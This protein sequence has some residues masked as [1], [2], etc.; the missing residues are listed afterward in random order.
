MSCMHVDPTNTLNS[1]VSYLLTQT[2]IHTRTHTYT[3]GLPEE[4]SYYLYLQR[5]NGEN[6][7]LAGKEI[8]Q[9]SCGGNHTAVLTTEN[10]LWMCGANP[11]GE[12][13]LGV[14][15][16]IVAE[17]TKVPTD[18]PV[19]KQIACGWSNH[20]A[21]LTEDG[22]L[23][24][25]GG[26]LSGGLARSGTKSS[27]EV[28]PFEKSIDRLCISSSSD[29]TVVISGN[30]VYAAGKNTNHQLGYPDVKNRERLV[31]LPFHTNA[32]TLHVV[33]GGYLTMVATGDEGELVL[34]EVQVPDVLL[35][36][37]NGEKVDEEQKKL[38]EKRNE[39]MK[40]LRMKRPPADKKTKTN[41]S[42]T[43][44]TT[45]TTTSN[46]KKT[47]TSGKGTSGG[48]VSTKS[49]VTSTIP[50]KNPNIR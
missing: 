46:S 47:T 37:K 18:L 7:S 43:T 36:E 5:M 24:T 3:Q 31:K 19:I 1:Y 2:L 44:A 8:K 17:F 6:S 50:R 21:L 42:N 41:T 4:Q 34:E 20:T 25:C 26:G 11:K 9:I 39:A 14:K 16:K 10:E 12:L 27:F 33:S 45:T 38:A 32:T 48:K 13:G 22:K 23:Y 30:E 35:E 40:R 28:V 15:S 49:S 29:S